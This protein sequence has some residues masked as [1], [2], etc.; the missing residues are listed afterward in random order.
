MP[1]LQ[2]LNLL[3]IQRLLCRPGTK[4]SL[5]STMSSE[6]NTVTHQLLRLI[7]ISLQLLKLGPTLSWKMH[8]WRMQQVTELL[9]KILHMLWA[10]P[11]ISEPTST[12]PQLLDGIAK[13]KITISQNQD[14][15]KKLVT[16]PR[17]FGKQLRRWVAVL[18]LM[19]QMFMSLADILLLETCRVPSQTTSS[20]LMKVNHSQLMIALA[21][22]N[23][24]MPNPN[25]NPDQELHQKSSN[26]IVTRMISAP[27]LVK[28]LKSKS[29]P[30]LQLRSAHRDMV[31]LASSRLSSSPRNASLAAKS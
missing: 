1:P 9:E 23:K 27:V 15:A 12:P 26:M 4:V 7:K 19:A 6:P 25:Y 11:K 24:P 22:Q 31:P 18:P 3:Q 30:L 8:R 13:S 17:L 5:P 20:H 28:P 14:S 16:L 2:Q 29:I 10:H 21:H